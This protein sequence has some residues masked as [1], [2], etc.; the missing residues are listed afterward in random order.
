[1]KHVRTLLA[2]GGATML[3]LG[4]GITQAFAANADPITPAGNIASNNPGAAN[5]Q[6]LLS[7]VGGRVLDIVFLIAGVLAVIYLVYNGIQYITSA[8]N[9]DK[10]KA[11]RSGIIN[12][13]IGIII[14]AAAYYIINFAIG[15]AGTANSEATSQIK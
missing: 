1:M 5:I 6:S 11:A 9:A 3:A 7:S 8:G 13:V 14:I 15:L 12:A 2:S 4:L 10:V